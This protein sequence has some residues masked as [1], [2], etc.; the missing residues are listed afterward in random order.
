VQESEDSERKI[1]GVGT[2]R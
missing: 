1:Y 2:V